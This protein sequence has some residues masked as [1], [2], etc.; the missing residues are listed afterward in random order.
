MCVPH[1]VRGQR[2]KT[3]DRR[4]LLALPALSALAAAFSAGVCCPLH[5][6]LL[7]TIALTSATCWPQPA[8]AVFPQVLQVVGRHMVK[9]RSG[10]GDRSLSVG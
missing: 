6:W 7:G 2:P 9:L 1:P 5:H 10:W 8:Q 3:R 4:P